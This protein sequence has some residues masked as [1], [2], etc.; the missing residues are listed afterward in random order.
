MY[1]K[2]VINEG[3]IVLCTVKRILP[4]SVF[5]SLDEYTNKEGMIHIS[6]ISPGRIRTLRDFVKE[7]RKIICKI[8]KIDRDHIDLSL[9]RVTTSVRINKL[10]EIKQEEKA[11]KLLKLIGTKLK[12][13]LPDMYKEIGN[14][15]I[16][17]YNSLNSFFQEISEN[18]QPE[19]KIEKKTL[20]IIKEQVKD[21]IKPQEVKVH[22][23]L[24]ITDYA[25]NGVEHIKKSLSQENKDIN[26]RY[27]SA[28]K[29][30]IEVISS[31]YKT[32]ET[33]LKKTT[34]EIINKIEKLGGKGEFKKHG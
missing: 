6:E 20:D 10:K 9:R 5:V 16:E 4:H 27:I 13:S 8:L 26:I 34:E 14:E 24:I 15:I 28:P 29:Y 23:N 18:K 22:G 1:K 33:I 19:I 11:E 21:K 2:K 32:A 25:S 31:D 7:G 17:H 12:K 3:D 30:K